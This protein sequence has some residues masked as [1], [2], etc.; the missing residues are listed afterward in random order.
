MY[1]TFRSRS[2]E[3][4]PGPS[5]D[6]VMRICLTGALLV[7][8]AVVA[9]P[10]SGQGVPGDFL[11]VFA[12]FV[13]DAPTGLTF[14]P[15]GN[16]YVSSSGSNQ[17][18]RF[19]GSTGASMG[20][21]ASGG[22]LRQPRGLVFGPDGNLYVCSSNTDEVLRYDGNTG[23]FLDSFAQGA[24]EPQYLV[25]GPG[26][27]LYVSSFFFERGL[28]FG[29]VLRYNATTGDLVDV[30]ALD[31]SGATGLAFGPGGPLY[32][33]SFS[34]SEVL[35]YEEVLGAW[36]GRGAFARDVRTPEGL[37]FGPDGNLY[38][39]SITADKVRRYDGASGARIDDFI[40]SGRGGLS[41][42][43]GLAF[44]PDG[45]L[46]VS[47]AGTNKVLRYRGF[48]T[49]DLDFGDAPTAAQSGFAS[50]YPVLLAANGA[51]HTNVADS[52]ILGSI[53]DQE[54]DGQPSSD[55]EG[56]DSVGGG[57]D[58]EDGVTWPPGLVR[59]ETARAETKVTL[60]APGQFR[61]NIWV[62]FT[63][64]GDW[65]DPGEQ[66]VNDLTSGS[67]NPQVFDQSY[68]ISVPASALL[69]TTYA[70]VRVC[71]SN[72]ECNSPTGEAL[73]GEVEDY[74]VT[75]ID[76][77]DFG[78]APD[79]FGTTL[80]SDGARHTTSTIFLGAS[81]DAEPDGLPGTDADGDDTDGTDDEDGVVLPAFI[82][83]SSTTVTVASF[84]ITSSG[85]GFVD[86]WMDSNGNGVFDLPQDAGGTESVSAGYRAVDWTFPPGY[87]QIPAGGSLTTYV[88]FRVSSAGGLGPTGAAADGEVEDYRVTVHDA[89]AQVANVVIDLSLFPV[90]TV[91]F[92]PATGDAVYLD[93][94]GSELYRAPATTLMN[95]TIT[96]T[97]G[98]D[99]LTVDM[100]F[101]NPF[102]NGMTFNAGGEGAIGDRLS[103]IQT[104]PAPPFVITDVTHRTQNAHD[105]TIDIDGSMIT[106]TGLE[107]VDLLLFHVNLTL[108]F[109][110]GS[111]TIALNAAGVAEGTDGNGVSFIDSDLGESTTF[112]HPTTTLTINAGTGND[113]VVI[114]ELDTGGS[115]P[116]TF[117]VN[118]DT[119]ADDITLDVSPF[120]AIAA[121]GGTPPAG[122]C[123][124][125]VLQFT[126]AA[127]EA[128]TTSPIT[129]PTSP[130][131]FSG[132]PAPMDV[133]QSGFENLGAAPTDLAVALRHVKDTAWP[134]DRVVIEVEVT[135]LGSSAV[136]CV[137][138]DL[139]GISPIL[140][141]DE[142]NLTSLPQPSATS[143]TFDKLT[144]VWAVVSV[145]AG[146]SETLSIPA[147]VNTAFGGRYESTASVTT[148]GTD[149]DPSNDE[150]TGYLTVLEPFL[151][152]AKAHPI[153]AAFDDDPGGLNRLL[154]GLFQG[155]PELDGSVLC[156]FPAPGILF[157]T[158]IHPKLYRLC[159]EGLPYPL[160]VNDLWRDDDGAQAGRVWLAS[161]GHKGLY[162]TDDVNG[163]WT[164]V[165]PTPGISKPG[166]VNVYAITEDATDGIL[167]ISA[168]NGRV[169]RSLDGGATW[170]AVAPLPGAAADTP[171]TLAAHPTIAG[172]VYAGT[173][174]RGV[175]VTDDF[176]FTWAETAGN[177]SLLAAYAGHVFDL[178]IIEDGGGFYL[179]AGTGRGIWRQGLSSP[180][181]GWTFTGPTVT[182]GARP[183]IRSLAVG[184][185]ASGDGEPDLY[186][187]SWG[188]GVFRT[189]TPL[190]GGVLAPFG[191]RAGNVTML[192]VAPGGM[193]VASI[194]GG[195]LVEMEASVA[196]FVD[197]N[198]APEVPTGYVLEQNYPNPFNPV[199]TIRYGVPEASWVRLAVFDML[200]R[201]VALLAD[202]F[203][204]A[205]AHEA[206]F[207]AGD[208]P[209]GVYIYRLEAP[210]TSLVRELTL[211]K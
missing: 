138:V 204:E 185:D 66:L 104:P 119:G 80:A 181:P 51:R 102:P 154:L 48:P 158:A 79:S 72:G 153:A 205:G 211:F 147:V 117:I 188:F 43:A 171:W 99:H 78:D 103:L 5:P 151:F 37:V 161:W 110:G 116:T 30:F 84:G 169:F 198:V 3:A 142:N 54:A 20:V 136:S 81:V 68:G 187:A 47:S 203:A 179:F 210:G 139:T 129:I 122:V 157:T 15:D 24:R 178:E 159:S 192:A 29:E 186:A 183:E 143:G 89:A 13:G 12:D 208:L 106:Y 195:G 165:E 44:G 2:G 111:E 56:D 155:S 65:D 76:P 38:V 96:G 114:G 90:T 127:G 77:A 184:V 75:I 67:I 108:P 8:L 150:G 173:F 107:P 18:L 52:P 206:V 39:S 42:P 60:R 85:A 16:L 92:D 196:T 113:T 148:F 128:I 209:S 25:F 101:G 174:G 133:T 199:T 87:F 53:I 71:P 141:I 109:A 162:Y 176:G 7:T 172:T 95:P 191:L 94:S 58:D 144:R 126:L 50:D 207:D 11:D 170:Q 140:E 175:Y 112:R 120:Y 152:P 69:G 4:A 73:G 202:R 91:T 40:P 62:D 23:V 35:F 115:Y 45:N 26:G 163:A 193:V 86:A 146:G 41:A 149:T 59:G 22:G 55:A 190:S 156:R 98:D 14:G 63:Q 74:Q 57:P 83:A 9:A 135:N 88:R 194:E 32:V 105:G 189:E 160:V 61:M 197:V 124:A 70:R 49:L 131:T 145:P 21:F 167:Y 27:F 28:I 6:R 36:I 82:V 137:T 164:E 97:P 100:T 93:A 177:G 125:D 132:T 34:S 33:G 121:N 201:E 166:W 46:Y 180:A 168:N 134:S 19:D 31:A 200:G 118:G 182:G 10:V 17:V 1:P 123:P 130:I 64:D